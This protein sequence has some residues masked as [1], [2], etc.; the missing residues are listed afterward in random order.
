MP[1]GAIERQVQIMVTER[2]THSD[3][4]HLFGPIEDHLAREILDLE[5]TA[6]E[7][8]VVAA[9]H[10][11]MT[12]VLGEERVPLA[13]NAARI[14]EIVSRDEVLPGEDEAPRA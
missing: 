6:A 1:I 13:G 10:A 2:S 8:E 4:V 7:L 3:I 5:P 14:Y 12:D 11:G 9:Y